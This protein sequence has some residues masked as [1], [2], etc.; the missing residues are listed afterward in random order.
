VADQYHPIYAGGQFRQG[1]GSIRQP[2]SPGDAHQ[3]LRRR[4]P[5]APQQRQG[6]HHPEGFQGRLQGAHDV[7]GAG[8]AVQQQD[9]A[10]VGVGWSLNWMVLSPKNGTARYWKWQ[11]CIAES[12]F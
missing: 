6:Y 4:G 2:V 12:D 10:A 5:V 1:C 7:G 11:Q 9:A 8:E 3:A